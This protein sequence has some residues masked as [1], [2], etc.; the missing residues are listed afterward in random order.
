V[1]LTTRIDPR[2]LLSGLFSTLHECGHGLYNQG[3]GPEL[4][5]TPLAHGAS[6]GVHESQ[7]RLWEN[8][9][10][11]SLDF[12]SHYFPKL[13][14]FFPAPL[15]GVPIEKFHRA[16]NRV[17]RSY[18]RVEADE[19]TYNL[20]IMLRFDLENELLE[21]KLETKHLPEAWNARMEDYLGL[22]PP[23]DA[24]GVLQDIHWSSGGFGYFPTYTLGNLISVQLYERASA[25]IPTLPKQ[26]AAGKFDELLAWLRQH[27][28][29]HGRKFTAMELLQKA[30]GRG[31]DPVPYLNYIR[32][33]YSDLYG[34]S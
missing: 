10:G 34:L 9:V 15:Q 8:L 27:I 1:R 11:R 18:I 33:K 3:I 25:A 12:W 26:M 7:S 20:H 22:T 13:Q 19:V 16:V 2:D 17:K 14:A 6:Q 5:R 28:H 23:D 24:L 29:Q 31:L 4:D 21:K 30:T 32:A